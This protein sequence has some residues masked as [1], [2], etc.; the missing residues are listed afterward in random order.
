LLLL[1][2]VYIKLIYLYYYITISSK[3]QEKKFKKAQI[4]VLAKEKEGKKTF[5][6]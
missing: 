5:K 4:I 6:I 2:L 1:K 3:L